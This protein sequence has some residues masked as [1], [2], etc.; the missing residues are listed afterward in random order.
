MQC[1]KIGIP[2]EGNVFVA[3]T[4]GK[5]GKSLEAKLFVKLEIL[6]DPIVFRGEGNQLFSCS[7]VVNGVVVPVFQNLGTLRPEESDNV[8]DKL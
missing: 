1:G 2:E 6:A 8:L 5:G 7:A 4:A 3:K